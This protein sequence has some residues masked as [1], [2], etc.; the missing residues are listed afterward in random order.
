MEFELIH[1]KFELIKL[2]MN[3]PNGIERNWNE[4]NGTD[5]IPCLN[6]TTQKGSTTKYRHPSTQIMLN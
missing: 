1:L 5:P 6:K 4:Q 2:N 3:L